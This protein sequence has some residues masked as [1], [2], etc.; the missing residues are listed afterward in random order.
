MKTT[1]IIGVI[2][3]LAGS[4]L[5]WRREGDLISF[6]SYGIRI[7]PS[8]QDNGGLI[9]VTLTLIVIVLTLRP[10][11][12]FGKPLMWSVFICLIL[13]ADTIFHIYKLLISRANAGGAVGT[14]VIQIGLIMVF[15]GS[16]LLLCS[17]SAKYFKLSL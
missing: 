4:F 14:P 12:I 9:V 17:T 11:N 6:W 16:I 15:V 3:I 7:F 2:L 1:F 5:P 13:V 8:I 10:P